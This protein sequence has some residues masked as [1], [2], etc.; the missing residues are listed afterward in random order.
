MFLLKTSIIFI[1]FQFS[2]LFSVEICLHEQKILE[3]FFKQ[4]FFDSEYG[5]VTEGV[6]PISTYEIPIF[7]CISPISIPFR[8]QINDL[9]AIALLDKSCFSHESNIKLKTN[10]IENEKHSFYYE[11]S[12]INVKALKTVICDH[13]EIFRSI[14]NSASSA[15]DILEEILQSKNLYRTL[16]N[17][18]I[19]IGLV[20]G[21]GLENSVLHARVE[22]LQDVDFHSEIIPFANTP[23]YR[24]GDYKLDSLDYHLWYMAIKPEILKI[25]ES[26]ITPS[27]GFNSIDDELNFL[28]SKKKNVASSIFKDHPKFIFCMYEHNE[29]FI[30]ALEN[31]QQNTQ[32]LVKKTD[33]LEIVLAKLGCTNFTGY[34][35][36]NNI[37]SLEDTLAKGIWKTALNF[38]SDLRIDFIQGFSK[39]I[40]RLSSKKKTGI[41]PGSYSKYK[42]AQMNLALAENRLNKLFETSD[43]NV[44]LPSKLGYQIIKEGN[45]KVLDYTKNQNLIVTYSIKDDFGRLLAEEKNKNLDISLTILGFTEGI[46]GMSEREM[47]VIYMHP[48]LAYGVLTTIPSC[49]NI[50]AEVTL[51]KI[52]DTQN[53]ILTKAKEVDLTFLTDPKISNEIEDSCRFLAFTLGSHW[54]T[55][56]NKDNSIDFEILSEKL[57]KLSQNNPYDI[58]LTVEEEEAFHVILWEIINKI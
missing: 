12:L 11:V 53:T 25:R 48:S 8:M 41:L 19:L 23:H 56:L 38:D 4:M 14:L 10:K 31:A 26:P 35:S 32:E 6:K 18:K 50:I 49:S 1:M 37:I 40:D 52:I 15:E 51:H 47:R 17:N 42:E 44:I 5:Y 34:Q 13:H 16:K 43:V 55:L 33:F 3:V 21:F 9:V 28:L 45:G 2:F 46:Q 22:N 24:L 36:R 30:K 58:D 39:K 20:L 27:F 57:T 29:N 54:R 7:D